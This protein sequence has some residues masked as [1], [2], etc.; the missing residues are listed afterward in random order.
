M[1]RLLSKSVF[2]KQ[3]AAWLKLETVSRPAPRR[4]RWIRKHNE[5]TDKSCWR[6]QVYMY[7]GNVHAKSTAGDGKDIFTEFEDFENA[8]PFE[9]GWELAPNCKL[10][11]GDEAAFVNVETEAV[12]G[13]KVRRLGAVVW[14]LGAMVWMLG[15]MV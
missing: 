12:T 1:F 5:T 14:M 9:S 2:S 4:R 3:S 8:S 10:P 15:A 6:Q 13:G 11:V 7:Y